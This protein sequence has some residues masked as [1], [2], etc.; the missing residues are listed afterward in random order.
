MADPFSSKS[1]LARTP[2]KEKEIGDT[3]VNESG[4]DMEADLGASKSVSKLSVTGGMKLARTPVSRPKKDIH[5]QSEVAGEPI[6]SAHRYGTTP[7]LPV[8][9]SPNGPEVATILDPMKPSP[10]HPAEKRGRD[11]SEEE[12]KYEDAVDEPMRL[13][14]EA[15]AAASDETATRYAPKQG[16]TAEGIGSPKQDRQQTASPAVQLQVD[17]ARYR[18]LGEQAAACIRMAVKSNLEAFELSKTIAKIKL[19]EAEWREKGAKLEREAAVL[20]N[21]IVAVDPNAATL[22]ETPSFS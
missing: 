6:N 11:I 7:Y 12:Q 8:A 9:E 13:L 21:E 1:Q 20:L 2:L 10:R 16:G 4:K 19:A 5:D 22:W 14:W 18:S 3:Q 17:M 15:E